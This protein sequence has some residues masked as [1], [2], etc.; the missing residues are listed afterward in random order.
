MFTGSGANNAPALAFQSQHI[1]DKPLIKGRGT[2]GKQRY[3][4]ALSAAQKLVYRHAESLAFDIVQGNID[5]GDGGG[6]HPATFKVGAA[7]HL[8]PE[9][10]DIERV[11]PL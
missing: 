6:Q 11:L 4:V 1:F 3:A 2:G 8:L 10:I 9:G 7:V 5:S